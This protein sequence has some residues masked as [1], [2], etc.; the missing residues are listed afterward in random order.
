MSTGA[1]VF[2][3]CAGV[4]WFW[5]VQSLQSEVRYDWIPKISNKHAVLEGPPFF[6]IVLFLATVSSSATVFGRWVLVHGRSIS[7]R[8]WFGMA[9]TTNET[10]DRVQTAPQAIT[11][12]RERGRGGFGE[13]GRGTWCRA[14]HWG[15]GAGFSLHV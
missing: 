10:F 15:C 5:R 13:A 14:T 3:T 2:D 11:R 4:G 8:D 6:F 7:W 12:R 1:H 9:M